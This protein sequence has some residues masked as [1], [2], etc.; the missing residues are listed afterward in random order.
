MLLVVHQDRI[1]WMHNVVHMPSFLQTFDENLASGY[2]EKSWLALYYAMILVGSS[3]SRLQLPGTLNNLQNQTTIYH[4]PTTD[5]EF[6]QGHIIGKYPC[7]KVH[8]I[9]PQHN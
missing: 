8:G 4:I 6:L 7:M 2:C 3:I 1:A 9:A 5:L